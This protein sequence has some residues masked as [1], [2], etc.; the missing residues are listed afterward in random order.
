MTI[1]PYRRSTVILCV[2]RQSP[3]A[4]AQA[5]GHGNVGYWDNIE[6][7]RRRRRQPNIDARPRRMAIN[8][9][10]R[11]PPPPPPIRGG[12]RARR[13]PVIYELSAGGTSH[14]PVASTIGRRPTEVV[15]RYTKNAP[16]GD[17]L[18]LLHTIYL[19]IFNRFGGPYLVGTYRT[20][21]C[22][23]LTLLDSAAVVVRSGS[24][25]NLVVGNAYYLHINISQ[26][27]NN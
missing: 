12:A 13:P 1:P 27:L 23:F 7:R 4:W 10:R 24:T 18:Y 8:H 9:L 26:I 6:R 25:D 21:S 20:H 11:T 16:D 14:Q 2:L 3:G 5:G 19:R 22:R 15:F 17:V